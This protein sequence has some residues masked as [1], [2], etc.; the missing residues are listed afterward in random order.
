MRNMDFVWTVE[1]QLSEKQIYYK[2][3]ESKEHA[4]KAYENLPK[5]NKNYVVTMQ[6]KWY[7]RKVA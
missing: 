2:E 7:E 3:F 5:D 6:R 1:M 4:W